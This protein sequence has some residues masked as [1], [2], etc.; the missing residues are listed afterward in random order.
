MKRSLFLSVVLLLT[1]TRA[2]AQ[3]TRVSNKNQSLTAY[4]GPAQTVELPNTVTLNGVVTPKPGSLSTTISWSAAGPGPVVFGSSGSAVTT[5]SFTVEGTYAMT[6][7]V[8]TAKL[9]VSNKTTVV[10]TKAPVVPPTFIANKL[11][12]DAVIPTA[13]A[14]V[15]GYNL[16]RTDGVCDDLTTFVKANT[17]LITTNSYNDDPRPAE[18]WCYYTKAVNSAGEGPASNVIWV[19]T[20]H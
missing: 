15:D 6:L 10:V 2:Y 18:A 9:Q 4:A 5:A 17:S 16:Y 8:K 20:K 3:P 11:G 7:S 12:W 1:V 19:P 13:T 14:P